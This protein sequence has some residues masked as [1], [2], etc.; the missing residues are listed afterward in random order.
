[1]SMFLTNGMLNDLS[2]CHNCQH[3]V[4]ETSLRHCFKVAMTAIIYIYI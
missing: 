4:F 1:M 2:L 3:C